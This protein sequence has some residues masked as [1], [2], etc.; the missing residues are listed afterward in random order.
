MDNGLVH[1]QEPLISLQQ[2]HIPAKVLVRGR[3][4]TPNVIPFR[5]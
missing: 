2:Y 4:G 5:K 1:R 3:R